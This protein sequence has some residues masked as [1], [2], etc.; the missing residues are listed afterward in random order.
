MAEKAGDSEE[1]EDGSAGGP[2]GFRGRAW[3]WILAA[4]ALAGLCI[5]VAAALL[6]R[7]RRGSG[8][9]STPPAAPGRPP[10]PTPSGGSP[11]TGQPPG[12][13]PAAPKGPSS[14]GN[15]GCSA[16]SAGQDACD[17][18]GRSCTGAF[19]DACSGSSSCGDPGSSCGDSGSGCAQPTSYAP[20][21]QL[22]TDLAAGIPQMFLRAQDRVTLPACAGVLAIRAYQRWISPRLSVRCRFTPSCSQFGLRAIQRY[23][24][25]AGSRL[26]LGRIQRCRVTVPCGSADPVPGY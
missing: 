17:E 19:S 18:L 13:V 9:D 10:L 26:A 15:D 16:C 22:L 12:P 11:G 4:A 6:M 5:V 25:L 24:L 14:C 3:H 23:G 2:A 8:A 21:A 7:I 1:P 20:H